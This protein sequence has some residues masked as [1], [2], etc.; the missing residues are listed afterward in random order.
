MQ[1][2]SYCASQTT[3]S[4]TVETGCCVSLRRF[5]NPALLQEFFCETHFATFGRQRVALCK[6]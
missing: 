1:K 4:I 3:V 6:S 5:I 2:P